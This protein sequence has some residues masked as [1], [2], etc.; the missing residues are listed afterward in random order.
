[1][2]G[3]GFFD[4]SNKATFYIFYLNYLFYFS[5]NF[6]GHHAEEKFLKN[7]FWVDVVSWL[8]KQDRI[9]CYEVKSTLRR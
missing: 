5:Y 7:F 9:G 4:E 8:Y 6:D 1:M 3:N 2:P